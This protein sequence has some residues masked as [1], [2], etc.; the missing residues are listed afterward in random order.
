MEQKPVFDKNTILLIVL[1]VGLWWLWQQ[2]LQQK[3]PEALNV[4]GSNIPAENQKET[5][6]SSNRDKIQGLGEGPSKLAGSG[7]SLDSAKTVSNIPEVLFNYEDSMLKAKVSSKGGRVVQL[8]LKKF[9]D[10]QGVP[11][12]LIGSDNPGYLGVSLEKENSKT[13]L[14]S[15]DYKLEKISDQSVSLTAQVKG[16]TV[17]KV[18]N[19]LPDKYL[20]HSHLEVSGDMH[21]LKRVDVAV[22]QSAPVVGDEKSSSFLSPKAGQEIQ[23]YFF[24]HGTKTTRKVST[25]KESVETN[26][27]QTSF[28]SLGSRYFTTLLYNKSNVFPVAQAFRQGSNSFLQLSYP[29]LDTGAP[30]AIDFDLY[31]GPKSVSQLAQVDEN[32]SKVVDF[33]FFSLIA[34]P[35]LQLMKWLYSIFNNYGV[36]II[37]LTILVRTLTF[38]FTYMSFKSMKSMQMIQPH[39]A[40]LKEQHKDNTA[41]LNQEMMKLMRDNKV[42]PM[43]GCLPMLLQLPVFWAL[44]QVLQNSI[45]LYHSPFAGWIHDLSLK[46]PYYVLP[47]LM[48]AAMFVQ[49]KMTPSTMDPAQARVMM[50]MPVLFSFLMVSL[51]SGLTLYI[52]VSTL[53]GIIQQTFMMKGQVK[54]AQVAQLSP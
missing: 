36:A 13:D 15:I 46:D 25:A 31:A 19:F 17:K 5:A 40:R 32:A 37:V 45:E 30:Q 53:F 54:P 14:S 48:G 39:I 7:V 1:C 52:F 29:V 34:F 12:S 50:I 23:E 41:V 47:V 33:G 44:Y 16:L 20:V 2:H 3:Y 11:V 10:R 4:A 51:P 24:S 38:P 28:A 27:D 42:N 21:D 43:G 18:L 6:V 9:T 8:E 35:L 22:A 49:Q 26:F